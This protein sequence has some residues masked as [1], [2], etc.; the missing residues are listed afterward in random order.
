LQ[1]CVGNHEVTQGTL[2]QKV[3]ETHPAEIKKFGFFFLGRY[4][5]V[6]DDNLVFVIF[7]YF[8]FF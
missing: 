5:H 8:Y 7:V 3:K 1:F 6:A 2:K 4:L